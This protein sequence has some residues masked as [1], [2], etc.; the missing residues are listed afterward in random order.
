MSRPPCQ[1]HPEDL[2]FADDPA[3]IEVAKALCRSC[4]LRPPC[5]ALAVDRGEPLGVWGGEV[6]HQGVVVARKPRA[7][8]PR[9]RP[10]AA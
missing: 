3:E 4:P 7:G 5:F 1:T 9:K 6:F 2:W 10:T 8:R